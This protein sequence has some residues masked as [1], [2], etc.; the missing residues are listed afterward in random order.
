MNETNLKIL[1]DQRSFIFLFKNLKYFF[2]KLFVI[3][4]CV[5]TANRKQLI[6]INDWQTVDFLL[7]V[8]A[9]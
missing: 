3:I 6:Y 7:S 5:Q 8:A 4:I 2:G 9:A 1:Y